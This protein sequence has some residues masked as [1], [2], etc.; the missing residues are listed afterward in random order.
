MLY[1]S[2]LSTNRVK[3]AILHKPQSV[4]VT[5]PQVHLSFSGA[6][7]PSSHL[8]LTFLDGYFKN[9][10]HG[11]YFKT[12]LWNVI[13]LQ[14]ISIVS[15]CIIHAQL[16]IASHSV[17][18]F[19]QLKITLTNNGPTM[20]FKVFFSPLF[21]GKMLVSMKLKELERNGPTSIGLLLN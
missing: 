1:H 6:H 19:I 21:H 20:A 2:T 14:S 15:I 10:G 17:R 18:E 8:L 5:D 13:R 9:F 7:E 12:D 16:N 3:L 11:D 4:L